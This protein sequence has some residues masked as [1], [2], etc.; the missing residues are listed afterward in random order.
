MNS[1]LHSHNIIYLKGQLKQAGIDEVDCLK[2][3]PYTCTVDL[4]AVPAEKLNQFNPDFSFGGGGFIY[5]FPSN[6][7][8]KFTALKKLPVLPK[9]GDWD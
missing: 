8:D 7:S 6:F 5:L 3:G 2:Q 9:I 1:F 4:T